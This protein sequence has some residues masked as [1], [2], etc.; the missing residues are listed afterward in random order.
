MSI[1]INAI[2]KNLKE[3]NV[4]IKTIEKIIGEGDIANIVQRMDEILDP[5]LKYHVLDAC[6]C[7]TKTSKAR[8]KECKEYGKKM[9]DKSLDEKIKNLSSINFGNV[10][11]NDNK[12]ITISFCWIID[13]KRYCSCGSSKNISIASRPSKDKKSANQDR[14]I[15]LSWCYCCA[16]HFRYHLQ[17]AL[18]LKLKTK[19]IISSPINSKGEKPCE[20][21]LEIIE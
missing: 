3:K 17:N 19:K 10:T 11:L 13:G 2:S 12:T 21:M 7:C 14:I 1:G 6:A 20:F 15:P 9:V 5:E 18:Q 16:G 8:D 4:D